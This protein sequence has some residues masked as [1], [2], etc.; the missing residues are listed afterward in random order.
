[1]K[2]V[3]RL[4]VIK[5]STLYVS[6]RRNKTHMTWGTLQD[7]IKKTQAIPKSVVIACIQRT[8][9]HVEKVRRFCYIL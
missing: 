6:Y 8:L 2:K 7:K 5:H 9:F 3:I 1:M 4:W